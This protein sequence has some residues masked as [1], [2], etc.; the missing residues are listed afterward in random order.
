MKNLNKHYAYYG[1]CYCDCTLIALSKVSNATHG[2]MCV[3]YVYG[4]TPQ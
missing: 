3:A 1:T 4:G 2:R